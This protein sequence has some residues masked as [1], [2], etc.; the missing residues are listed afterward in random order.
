ML[1]NWKCKQTITAASLDCYKS[2]TIYGDTL[3]L[4]RN[5]GFIEVYKIGQGLKKKIEYKSHSPCFDY[6]RSTEITESIDSI[7][8]VP[9]GT[10]ETL[11]LSANQKN[12]K[13]WNVYSSF[14][15][16][17][18]TTPIVECCTDSSFSCDVS[19]EKAS[20]SEETSEKMKKLFACDSKKKTRVK[21]EKEYTP[22]N[23]YNIHSVSVSYTGENIL[24]SD[25]LTITLLNSRLENPWIPLNLKPSKNEEL[26][27][28]ITTARFLD[29]SASIFIYGTAGGTMHI[30]DLRDC[31]H[32][33]PMLSVNSSQRKDFYKEVVQPIADIQ[34]LSD[35]LIASRDLEY[36]VVNDIRSSSSPVQ[37]YDVYPLVRKKI[38]ELYDSDEIFSRFKMA[39]SGKK[40]YTGSFNTVLAEVDTEAGSV[41]RV[42]LEDALESTPRI[43]EGTKV[44]CISIKDDCL[45]SA[46][47]NQCYIFRSSAETAQ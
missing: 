38:S 18:N 27:K 26:S 29:N 43:I 37:E 34:F 17:E 12:L 35:T 14:I 16:T 24:M 44:S 5:K 19:D 45:V 7:D 40:I 11:V 13:L 8:I 2:S 20:Q 10:K 4:G 21:L 42:F 25:E 33:G 30:H 47:G 1:S 15:G 39:V 28:V 36:V 32:A 46:Y 9:S 23:I 3:V 31:S 6:L 41:S 22:E